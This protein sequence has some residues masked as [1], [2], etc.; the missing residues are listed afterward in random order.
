MEC[1]RRRKK[2]LRGEGKVL[3]FSKLEL[4]PL[5]EP[6]PCQ[7]GVLLPGGKS[8]RL[9]LSLSLSLPLSVRPNAVKMADQ[10]TSLSPSLS[11]ALSSPAGQLFQEAG[12]DARARPACIGHREHGGERGKYSD[13]RR[14][15][16]RWR[17][18]KENRSSHVQFRLLRSQPKQRK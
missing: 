7:A 18:A 10:L 5:V 8:F 14:R 16:R 1:S 3:A 4:Q 2:K 12:S 17:K 9:P 15:R 6:L 13:R 11:R